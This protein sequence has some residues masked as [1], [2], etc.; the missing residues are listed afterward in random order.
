VQVLDGKLAGDL[1]QGVVEF[2]NT[3][4]ADALMEHETD[5]QPQRAVR[6]SIHTNA[7]R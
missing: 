5:I 2:K 1:H 4:E 6:F 7:K 3:A